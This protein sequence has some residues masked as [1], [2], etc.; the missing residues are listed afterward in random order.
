MEYKTPVNPGFLGSQWRPKL[1]AL[2]AFLLVNVAATEYLAWAFLR[3]GYYFEPAR[4]HVAGVGLY[5]PFCWIRWEFQYWRWVL[6]PTPPMSKPLWIAVAIFLI[7]GLLGSKLVSQIV[8]T[9]TARALT[10]GMEH[11]YGSSRWAKKK[12]LKRAGLLDARN[13]GGVVFGLWREER[14]KLAKW[15]LKVFRISRIS[16]PEWVYL[17]DKS[18][19]H[20]LV[21]AATETGKTASTVIMSA[22]EWEGGMLVLDVKE[23][24]YKATAGWRQQQ[25]HM[26]LKFSPKDRTGCARFN[27]LSFVRL[28]TDYEISDAQLIAEA[29]GNPG[30]E[31]ESSAHWNETSASLIT[32]VLLHELYKVRRE[33]NRLATLRDVSIGLSPFDIE[34]K[35]YLQSMTTYEHDPEGV[36]GWTLPDGRPTKVHPVVWEKAK[37]ALAR[38]EEEAG[39]VQ[40]TGKKRF[41]LFVDPLVNYATSACD[42]RV[43]DLVDESRRVSVYM[44]IP[45]ADRERLAP[46]IRVITMCVLNRIAE[47]RVVRRHKLLALLDEVAVLGYVKQLESTPSYI[48]DYGVKLMFVVQD[49]GQIIKHYGERNEL[50]TNCQFKLTF[51]V[52]ELETARTLSA[53]L[54]TFTVQHASFNFN[55]KPK[56]LL[57]G[58]GVSANL[59]NTKRALAEPEELMALETPR[60]EGDR[61]T[62]PGEF[63]M[64]IFGCP[65]VKG[66]QGFWFLDPLVAKRVHLPITDQ[67]SALSVDFFKSELEKVSA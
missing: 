42:W 31:G 6:H 57:D 22:L 49:I 12:D 35:A 64:T 1:A 53:T 27:P 55:Q 21:A 7:G 45:P 63:V 47:K 32:G 9:L 26:C 30:R 58:E 66:R 46:L 5:Q 24:I 39:S 44:V 41:S 15:L 25:G 18:S 17:R 19:R 14:S 62:Y 3:L 65:P 54:G 67:S 61:V 38:A 52:N 2:L 51:A 36:R 50:A 60:R 59:Q 20:I 56:L 11:I 34:F 4:L 28:G 16:R 10:K 23:E 43:D 33:Q 37:E 13:Q 40:S 8:H 48:R 29:L